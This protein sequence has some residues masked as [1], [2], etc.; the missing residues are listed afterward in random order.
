MGAIVSPHRP[1]FFLRPLVVP[2]SRLT[3]AEFI[4]TLI[5]MRLP[6]DMDIIRVKMAVLVTY[7]V[8]IIMGQIVFRVRTIM[9][10]VVV[11]VGSIMRQVHTIMEV[12]GSIESLVRTIMDETVEA[13]GPI[14]IMEAA[15]VLAGR[16]MPPARITMTSITPQ[17]HTIISNNNPSPTNLEV[18]LE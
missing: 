15:V 7:Q 18:T 1:Y 3:W 17:V 2:I 14:K 12:V 6:E 8:N 10:A 11:L 4:S 9:E 5:P 16:I 13:V